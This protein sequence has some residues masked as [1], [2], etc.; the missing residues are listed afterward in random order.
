M[1][2]AARPGLS[3]TGELALHHYEQR[4]HVEEDLS[5]VATQNYLNDL[6][7]F[8][9]WC[10]STWQHGREEVLTFTPEAMTRP[11]LID[12]RTYLQQTLHL[13]PNSVN[14]SLISIKRDFV[15]LT[16]SGQYRYDQ[17]RIVKL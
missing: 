9:A 12:Y 10:E 13:K 1:K 4:F 17:A 6:R 15:W 14:C 2:R 3:P 11:T 8:A 7:H 5:A 16:T